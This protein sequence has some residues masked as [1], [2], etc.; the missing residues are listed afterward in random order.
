[1][2][3]PAIDEFKAYIKKHS[4][5]TQENAKIEGRLNFLSPPPSY[6]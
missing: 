2:E 5:L 6:N 3:G 1:M 4:P